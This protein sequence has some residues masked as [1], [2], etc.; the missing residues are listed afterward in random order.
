MPESTNTQHQVDEFLAWLRQIHLEQE[1]A[2][3]GSTQCWCGCWVGLNTD[4][5]LGLSL[6]SQRSVAEKG[7]LQSDVATNREEALCKPT[8]V[9]ADSNVIFFE[10]FEKAQEH[11]TN[12]TEA[13]DS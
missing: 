6:S 1:H 12:E 8:V 3:C 5:I 13:E 4:I 9:G 10:L 7:I 11:Q 2:N